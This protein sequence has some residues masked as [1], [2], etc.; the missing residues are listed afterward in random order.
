MQPWL[1]DEVQFYRR[2]LSLSLKRDLAR[3]GTA[4]TSEQK[5]THLRIVS[6]YRREGRGQL[7]WRSY[8]DAAGIKK[9]PFCFTCSLCASSAF[10]ADRMLPSTYRT[11]RSELQVEPS[12]I[13]RIGYRI[14][15]DIGIRETKKKKKKIRKIP[16]EIL[17]Y[18]YSWQKV[19]DRAQVLVQHKYL[20]TLEN[21]MV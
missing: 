10:I 12:T 5:R 8:T 6:S 2:S 1:K 15:V 4:C 14:L 9:V 13:K 3:G 21:C 18:N 17:F 19:L 7:P 16:D 11:R 20:K